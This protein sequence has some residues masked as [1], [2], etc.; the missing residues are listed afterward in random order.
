MFTNPVTWLLDRTWYAL[1]A[2]VMPAP[3]DHDEFVA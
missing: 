2:R 3:S 1:V